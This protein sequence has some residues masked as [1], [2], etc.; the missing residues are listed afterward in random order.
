MSASNTKFIMRAD[1]FEVVPASAR[2]RNSIRITSKATYDDAVFVLDLAHMP[3]G[4]ATWPAWWTLSS[5]GP[6]P[7]GGEIDIIEGESLRPFPAVPFKWTLYFLG[8]NQNTQNLASLHTS[9][10][11]SMSQ[12]RSQTGCVSI[13]LDAYQKLTF[14]FPQ[15]IC[16]HQL[17]C[18]C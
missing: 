15:T 5:S 13:Y 6:W 7:Q 4:C 8:V 10:G 16:I 12:S 18:V 9:P 1:A 2:G 14:P 3:Q 17:R 11:C